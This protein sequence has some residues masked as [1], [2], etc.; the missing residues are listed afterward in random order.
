[1]HNIY[2]PTGGHATGYAD[3]RAIAEYVIENAAPWQAT[4]VSPTHAGIFP[5]RNAAP[6]ALFDLAGRRMPAVPDRGDMMLRRLTHPEC[7][8]SG[9]GSAVHAMP[10]SR[11]D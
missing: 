5:H 6:T 11:R 8:V 4:T 9:S 2:Y 1:V 10:V 7:A 3:A